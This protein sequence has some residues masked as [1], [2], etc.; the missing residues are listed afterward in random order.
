MT[1]F[2]ELV[3]ERVPLPSLFGRVPVSRKR[4]NKSKIP[5]FMDFE[6]TVRFLEG[7]A[8]FAGITPEQLRTVAA[9]ATIEN[10][11]VGSMGYRGRRRE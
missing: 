7:S 11:P 3:W 6:E 2:L 4:Y 9:S 1:G 5:Y 8:L 10:H